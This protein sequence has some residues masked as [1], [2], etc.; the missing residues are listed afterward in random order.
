MPAKGR[1]EEV[2]IEGGGN[3]ADLDEIESAEG[4][5]AGGVL[6]GTRNEQ[7]ENRCGPDEEQEIGG[8]GTEGGARDKA[9]IVG[10]DGLSQCFQREGDGQQKPGLASVS[11][12]AAG[13][14]EGGSSSQEAH[15]NVQGIGEK[16]AGGGGVKQC[17]VED[18]KKG[19]EESGRDGNPRRLAGR[20]QGNLTSNESDKPGGAGNGTSVHHYVVLEEEGRT[21][22]FLSDKWLV[23]S[24]VEKGVLRRWF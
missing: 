9:L 21:G 4:I 3:D 22:E 6:V 12:R 2:K 17:E 20:E 11:G 13:D 14:V 16:E 18:E 19:Q 10:A 24:N 1:V 7:H 15:G 23:L 5:E 8:I